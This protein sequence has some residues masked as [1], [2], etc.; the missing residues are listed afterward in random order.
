MKTIKQ[1]LIYLFLIFIICPINIFASPP[2]PPPLPPPPPMAP[3][4]PPST[5]QQ[6]EKPTT[7]FDPAAIQEQLKKIKK[8]KEEKKEETPKQQLVKAINRMFEE[9]IKKEKLKEH[10]ENAKK[11]ISKN[12]SLKLPIIKKALIE[13]TKK[14]P[15][16][17]DAF[18]LLDEDTQKTFFSELLKKQLKLSVE[19]IKIIELE[20]KKNAEQKIK[21]IN[22]SF[23]NQFEYISKITKK[24]KQKKIEEILNYI[25]TLL[26]SNKISAETIE[27]VK[28]NYIKNKVIATTF[29]D[30]LVDNL[31]KFKKILEQLNINQNL[32]EAIEQEASKLKSNEAIVSK[33]TSMQKAEKITK[34]VLNNL[35]KEILKIKDKTIIKEETKRT[36][37]NIIDKEAFI[38]KTVKLNP[39]QYTT[40]KKNLGALGIQKEN[41]DAF[42]QKIENVKLKEEEKKKEEK[43]RKEREKKKQEEKEQKA[44]ELEKKQ[45]GDIVYNTK[46]IFNQKIDIINLTKSINNL[47]DIVRFPKD[48]SAQTNQILKIINDNILK[49]WF[50]NN[51]IDLETS[52]QNKFFWILA[53]LNI[54]EKTVNEFKENC[55]NQ[56]EKEAPDFAKTIKKYLLKEEEEGERFSL[57]ETIKEGKY[58]WI[59][60]LASKA[61]N[62]AWKDALK[63]EDI[64]IDINLKNNAGQTILQTAIIDANLNNPNVFKSVYYLLKDK[65]PTPPELSKLPILDQTEYIVTTEENPET[66]IKNIENLKSTVDDNQNLNENEK[67]ILKQLIDLE[68]VLLTTQEK[69]K[70]IPRTVY[71]V[72]ATE[73]KGEEKSSLFE[74]LETRFQAIKGKSKPSKKT[75]TLKQLKAFIKKILS[76]LS[77]IHKDSLEYYKKLLEKQQ[78][79]ESL[80]LD[81]NEIKKEIEEIEGKKVEEIKEE[82]EWG[83]KEEE[84]QKPKARRRIIRLTPKTKPTPKA[85]RKIIRPTPKAKPKEKTVQ[86]KIEGELSFEEKIKLFGGK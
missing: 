73:E 35:N 72:L 4:A 84:E 47:Y 79:Y 55:N 85:R 25:K 56:I 2:A 20:V 51:F 52:I 29:K 69:M 75:L 77:L 41:I 46:N 39:E 49:L 31:E 12:T 64:E 53:Q 59:K 7:P 44:K 36:V 42:D 21:H 61:D 11:I 28:N 10:I 15:D 23:I 81:T 62:K 27:K 48:I 45:K 16:F 65:L 37:T 63:K 5:L 33:F 8:K 74:Q 3:G 68:K 26:D 57:T 66:L 24:T 67:T 78:S 71:Q 30:L 6:A 82:E 17:Y 76:H 14:A 60:D 80:E 13:K 40:L 22:N 83:K 32:I 9:N 19:Q 50:A 1:I 70:T 18:I 58:Y 34:I 86:K 38:T 43:N 54:A